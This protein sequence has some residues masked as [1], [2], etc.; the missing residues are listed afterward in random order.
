MVPGVCPAPTACELWRA[1]P[2]DPVTSVAAGWS[3]SHGSRTQ[4]GLRKCPLWN[5]GDLGSKPRMSPSLPEPWFA[6][7]IVPRRA[8]HPAPSR[9][10]ELVS[11]RLAS[12]GHV[13]FPRRGGDVLTPRSACPSDCDTPPPPMTS[14]AGTATGNSE[15]SVRSPHS[16][17]ALIRQQ[18]LARLRPT[19]ASGTRKL[20]S[21]GHDGAP[22][23]DVERSEPRTPHVLTPGGQ[24]QGQTSCGR[25]ECHSAVP[26]G[27]RSPRPGL[28]TVTAARPPWS[29][30]GCCFW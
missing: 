16:T 8:Q 14:P 20:K 3:A 10:D 1:V 19:E 4:R 29:S 2:S 15:G 30:A 21:R 26:G 17:K 12:V 23:R 9:A 25:E 24:N 28:G 11:A 13:C 6:T 22:E 18:S 7:D 5:P 27:P